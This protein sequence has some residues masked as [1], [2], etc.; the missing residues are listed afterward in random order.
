ME[1]NK[2][3]DYTTLLVGASG[4]GA[5]SMVVNATGCGFDPHSGISFG[6]EAKCGKNVI[7]PR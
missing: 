6:V 3:N 5:Q 2:N 4:A 7:P 1:D